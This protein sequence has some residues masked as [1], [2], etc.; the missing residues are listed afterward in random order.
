LTMHT[1]NY[2]FL[3]IFLVKYNF[4]SKNF[5]VPNIWNDSGRS[6]YKKTI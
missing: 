1:D 6:C 4:E 3:T 2:F 5:Q